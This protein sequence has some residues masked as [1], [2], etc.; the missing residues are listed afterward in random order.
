MFSLDKV[1]DV[2]NEQLT[3][4]AEEI[5]DDFIR[6][7]VEDEAEINRQ[8]RIQDFIWKP[9]IRLH[10]IDVPQQHVCKEEEEVEAEQQFCHQ[11]R[12]SS[13]D[14]EDPEPPQMK[15]EQEEE[16]LKQEET[17]ALI[18]TPT[19]EEDVLQQHVCK[20]E[21]VEPE[22]QLCH[23]ERKSSL[24]QEDPE[25][26]QIKEEQEEEQLKQEET[27]TLILTPTQEESEQS[28][29]D[30]QNEHQFLSHNSHVAENQDPKEN[31]QKASE[32]TVKSKPRQE[33]E[34]KH[35]ELGAVIVGLQWVEEVRPDRVVVCTDSAATLE[36]F[37][38]QN[39]AEKTLSW[40][41]NIAC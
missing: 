2:V 8:R 5:C 15:E 12:K 27:D 9:H 33:T 25:P 29:A 7:V 26:P 22:Q 35:T 18:L 24:D 14:Q 31:K 41:Y 30:G 40:S 36:A 39:Q 23:Q 28:E 19:Q 4:A 20:E 1:R 21:E 17:D 3:A 32:M 34:R 13:L 16:Q 6:T 37:N 11:E 38:Q 10:R